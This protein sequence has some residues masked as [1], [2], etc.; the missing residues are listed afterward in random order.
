MSVVFEKK[1][2][3]LLMGVLPFIWIGQ[4]I[5]QEAEIERMGSGKCEP[6]L[7]IGTP[8]GQ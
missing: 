7:E 1:N 6:G 5:K 4:Y 8:E 2:L 3:F